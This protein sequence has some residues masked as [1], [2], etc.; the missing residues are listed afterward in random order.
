MHRAFPT[1]APAQR[2]REIEKGV[3]SNESHTRTARTHGGQVNYQQA[4]LLN[5]LSEQMR[6]MTARVTELEKLITLLL[7]REA[8]NVRS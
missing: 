6:E 5:S 4:S 3:A 8:A 2:V 1:Q 7:E